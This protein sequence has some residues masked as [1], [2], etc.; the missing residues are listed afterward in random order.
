MRVGGFDAGCNRVSGTLLRGRFELTNGE[1]QNIVT[2]SRDL[3]H[4]DAWQ[5]AFAGSPVSQLTPSIKIRR[6]SIKQ[7]GHPIDRRGRQKWQ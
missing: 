4:P 3:M 6:Q 2:L 7:G 1:T 5:A